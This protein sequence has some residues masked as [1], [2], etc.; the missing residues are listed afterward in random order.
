MCV[1]CVCV[2][3]SVFVS[4]CVCVR[5]SV[6]MCVCACACM[7]VCVC[8]RK[9]VCKREYVCERECV[10]VY[11]CTFVS[12]VH[13]SSF[14]PL[15]SPLPPLFFFPHFT[16]F[17]IP[18]PYFSSPSSTQLPSS[19]HSTPLLTTHLF[20]LFLITQT[21]SSTQDIIQTTRCCHRA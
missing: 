19:H 7:C 21:A 3:V 2:C 5:E 17:L 4:V 15:P 20:P 10:Y 6:S 16:P 13:S 14:L 12:F 18:T 9:C 8:K 11:V 1:G